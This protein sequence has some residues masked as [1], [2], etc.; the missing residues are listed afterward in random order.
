MIKLFGYV[1]VRETEY[2]AAI[3]QTIALKAAFDAEKKF[4]QELNTYL[5]KVL[6][7]RTTLENKLA[8]AEKRVKIGD[9]HELRCKIRLLKDCE[10]ALTDSE[11]AR[12]VLFDE[13]I[14]LTEQLKDARKPKRRKRKPT[15]RAK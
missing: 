9:W 3:D 4:G 11:K 2:I 13:V 6:K 12:A 5:A 10:Q 1:L 15:K 7:E 8:I 14:T